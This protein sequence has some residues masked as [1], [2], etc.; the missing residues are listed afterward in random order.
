MKS[1]LNLRAGNGPARTF[2]ILGGVAAALVAVATPLPGFGSSTAAA[3]SRR[4]AQ[5]LESDGV[6]E[7]YRARGGRPLWL[8]SPQGSVAAQQLFEMLN[9]AN[10][11][12]FDR[13]R[14]QVG[15]LS[16]ALRDAR[17]G[18]P[19]AV[20]RAETMLSQAFVTYA[21]DMRRQ[22]AIAITYVDPELK[23]MLP[24]G[25]SLLNMAASAP[26]LTDWVRNVG[27]MHPTYGQL[28]RTLAGRMYMNEG[29]RRLLS[30]NLQRARALPVT[31]S[32]YVVV[33]AAAQRLYMYENGE[34]V[35]YM[36]VVVGKPQQP[37][38]MMTALIRFASLNPYWN[39]PPDLAV[40][41]IVPNVVKGGMPYLK[42]KGYQ[43]LSD[44]GENARLVDPKSINWKAVA[45]GQ[46]EVRLRQLPG[47]ANSM[48]RMKFMFPNREGIYLH[49]TPD[50]EKLTEA[51]RLFSGGCVRLEDA[52]RLGRWMF[53]RA[54][55]PAGA[56]PEQKVMLNQ[57][58]PVYL[59]YLTAVPSGSQIAYF[60][61]IY[62]R[63]SQRMASA[64]GRVR[65]SR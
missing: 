38:P 37:T 11:D 31:R 33:N 14:Y 56:R 35:D 44:W 18:D 27:W 34:V 59:T 40:E 45:G 13:N 12:G 4:G 30:I 52:P 20:N 6:Q 60:E 39:V 7:F 15:R 19:R 61:D 63:D 16:K 36:R 49:D 2:V 22:P 1:S 50:K 29:Q 24:S 21:R 53:G 47:P 5:G 65:A 46:G 17:R 42:A 48:G 10:V 58:V 28:R 3:Q 8:A 25:L 51:S 64:G 54:L 23:P 55:K 32:R 57:P 41:R 26:S 62:G 9:S 43:V